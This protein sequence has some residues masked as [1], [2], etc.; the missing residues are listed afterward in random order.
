MLSKVINMV[1]FERFD[2]EKALEELTLQEKIALTTG[3]CSHQLIY[4]IDIAFPRL[5]LFLSS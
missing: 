1:A 3:N 4:N 5:T 2:V